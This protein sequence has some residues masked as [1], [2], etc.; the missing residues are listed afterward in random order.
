MLR[1]VERFLI[2]HRGH[3]LAVVPNDDALL[4]LE[5]GYELGIDWQDDPDA[6]MAT[7]VE[8]DFEDDVRAARPRLT[9]RLVVG[10]ASPR[11]DGE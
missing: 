11:R 4:Y 2:L 7:P 9:Q 10:K 6:L 8:P 1:V 5:D 3:D